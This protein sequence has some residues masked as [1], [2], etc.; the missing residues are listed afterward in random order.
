MNAH[1]AINLASQYAG[2]ASPDWNKRFVEGL[3]QLG[4]QILPIAPRRWDDVM[5]P[6]PHHLGEQYPY[7][8]IVVKGRP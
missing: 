1:E 3:A 4:W 8:G 5:V 7:P 6:L 2:A